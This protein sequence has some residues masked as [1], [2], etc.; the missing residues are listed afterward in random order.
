M[1]I[2]SANV[3]RIFAQKGEFNIE[4][5]SFICILWTTLVED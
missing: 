4:T 1:G 5:A 2:N 3:E